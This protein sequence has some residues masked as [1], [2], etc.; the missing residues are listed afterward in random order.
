MAALA[1]LRVPD[2]DLPALTQQLGRI[3]SYIDQL[4]EIR[5]EPRRDPDVTATPL[6][7]DRE[8]PGRGREALEENSPKL[9]HDYGAVPRV[10]G[11]AKP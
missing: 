5:E 6:R 3:L 7:E 8:L 9:L 4:K 1:R 10:V 11:Q 2:E